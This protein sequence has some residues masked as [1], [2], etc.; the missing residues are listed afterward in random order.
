M[1]GSSFQVQVDRPL[2]HSDG[3]LSCGIEIARHMCAGSSPNQTQSCRL[4]DMQ[5]VRNSLTGNFKV[6]ESAF[7]SA[8]IVRAVGNADCHPYHA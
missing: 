4:S 6:Y 1:S 8:R 3:R 7:E 2:G 5:D